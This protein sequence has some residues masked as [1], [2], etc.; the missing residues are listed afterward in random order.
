MK[1]PKSINISLVARRS[2]FALALSIL[3]SPYSSPWAI[4]A[5]PNAP[6]FSQS[7]LQIVVDN[8]YAAFYG[9]SSNVNQLLNQNNVD[10]GT[11]V[12]NASTL[13]IVGSETQT[14]VYIVAMG[15]GGNEDYGGR[16]N[17]Q[18]VT[19]ISGAQF[20]E[21]ASHTSTFGSGS[22]TNSYLEI[23]SFLTG[24]SSADAAAGTYN[25][26]LSDLQ[27]ALSGASWGSAVATGS[28]NGV[29]PN[30]KTSG[31]ACTASSAGYVATGR[32]WD[33]PSD[34]AV[35][36]RYPISSLSTPVTAGNRQ[37]VI[38]WST[39]S[40]GG[41]PD[42]YIVQYKRTSDPD[43][44]FT[45]FSTPTNVNNE[46]VTSLTNGVNYSF[47]VAAS[48][49]DGT[50]AYT[51]VR[52]A[53]PTGP[54]DAPTS[55]TAT[56]ASGSATIS[57]TAP[58]S[59]GGSAITNYQ[60]S[61][62]DGATWTAFSPTVVA[63]PV[64][65]SGLTNGTTY[66]IRLRAI[67]ALGNGDSSTSLSVIPGAPFTITYDSQGGSS[68]SNGSSVTGGNI[69]TS[70]G[71][72]SR[73]FHTFRGWFVDPSG[74]TAITFPYTHGKSAAFTLYAQWTD[75]RSAQ[76]L[77]F[78]STFT[79]ALPNSSFTVSATSS[80]GASVTY[81]SD[82][83][84]VCTISDNKV[85]TKFSGTCI[86]VASSGQTTRAGVTY[87]ATSSTLTFVLTSAN[88]LRPRDLIASSP[89]LSA[90]PDKLA[91]KPGTFVMSRNPDSSIFPQYVSYTL[92]VSGKA[93]LTLIFN[94]GIN[95]AAWQTPW[96]SKNRSKLTSLGEISVN[97]E[98]S[99][100]GKE[101]YVEEFAFH[102]ESVAAMR[103]AT[104]L[105]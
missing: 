35:V 59:N 86:I 85:V 46:T 49:A 17:G 47:R 23:K 83:P 89:T 42:N 94:E 4:A 102:G 54:P 57:F 78:E 12:S 88:F 5:P 90:S 26:S 68:I 32:C 65:I 99:W 64:T 21:T 40:G 36:F 25:V 20:A 100:R 53:T 91:I 7:R 37:V 84:D 2:F 1:K 31:V 69:S 79:E 75:N 8:D 50:S 44:A 30:F 38:T 51:A 76:S 77:T 58:A 103:T 3:L 9:D 43:S 66:P 93:E 67:S 60:Y 11:Q 98:S 96:Y 29:P 16:L 55:L 101:I 61:I 15:G 104:L 14:Y 63:S 33:I 41:T 34:Q 92:Y 19:G 62:N 18:D 56:V 27:S 95:L 105:P 73:E 80:I 87:L 22:K 48:N 70:P 72:P 6:T 24:Y 10:W 97:L 28:G 13:D 71:S 39:P 45:T 74:G 82:T 52:T 81:R